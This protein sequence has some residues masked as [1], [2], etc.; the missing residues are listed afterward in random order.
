[1]PELSVV[2]SVHNGEPFLTEAIDS[3]LAQ[4]FRDFELIMIDDASTDNSSAV[5]EAYHDQRVHIVHHTQRRGVAASF[6][7][8]IAHA[9]GQY[10]A[11]MNA[12]D[13]ALPSRFS[14]QLAFLQTHPQ[15]G[16]VG[17]EYACIDA[18]GQMMRQSLQPEDFN[19]VQSMYLLR[20]RLLWRPALIHPGW[21]LRR[22]I[23][24]AHDLR[25]N[26]TLVA[27]EDYDLLC[28]IA[29]VSELGIVP[30]ILLH[31]RQHTDSV[32]SQQRQ[33][34]RYEHL[35]I[36]RRQLERLEGD[37]QPHIASGLPTAF[38]VL[39]VH[40]DDW[41][42][43]PPNFNAALQLVLHAYSAFSA[44]YRLDTIAHGQ[45]R[46]HTATMLGKLIR[47]AW[48]RRAIGA[49]GSGLLH[50]WRIATPTQRIVF[51]KRIMQR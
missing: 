24:D 19:K 5:I 9:T 43:Q 20:W 38:A 46:H 45:I 48:R 13:V 17:V 4:D 16:C 22:T 31:Y 42:P 40:E 12:D 2:M 29:E 8:G 41:L 11:V 32:S 50:W 7:H 21:M 25:Y 6:N 15:V 27:A 33:R 18:A 34:Q 28:H 30:E 35:A 36:T 49:V 26:E 23:L 14:K 39:V 10:V 47:A 51:T 44:T 1:M 37:H 3:V